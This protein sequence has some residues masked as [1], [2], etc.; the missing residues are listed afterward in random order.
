MNTSYVLFL[1][2]DESGKDFA[3]P[4]SNPQPLGM[5]RDLL[6]VTRAKGLSRLEVLP[7]ELTASLHAP[8]PRTVAS[9]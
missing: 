4:L 9:K 7:P 8:G 6:K 1:A 5:W 3:G 2:S